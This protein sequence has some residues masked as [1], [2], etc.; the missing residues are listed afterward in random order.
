MKYYCGPSHMSSISLHFWEVGNG[1]NI[2]NFWYAVKRLSYSEIIHGELL[3]RSK[4][5]ATLQELSNW[6]E[7][8]TATQKLLLQFL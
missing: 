4:K 1:E 5:S 2:I 3:Q 6:I 8:I 7:E